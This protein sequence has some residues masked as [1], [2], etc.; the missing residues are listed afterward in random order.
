MQ[1]DIIFFWHPF[2]MT[3]SIYEHY[4][5]AYS[6][7]QY[8]HTSRQVVENRYSIDLTFDRKSIILITAHSGSAHALHRV[9]KL[10]RI[11]SGNSCQPL[12]KVNRIFS[13]N[14]PNVAFWPNELRWIIA[15][16][17]DC[18]LPFISSTATE[19]SKMADVVPSGAC[20]Y[21]H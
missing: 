19:I 14:T 2:E 1:N 9:V 13:K 4:R 17:N 8:I 3:C 16:E 10:P 18:M 15:L 20:I 6:I 11:W 5:A 7:I 12:C 21:P